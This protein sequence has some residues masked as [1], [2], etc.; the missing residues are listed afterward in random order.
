M[1]QGE[2]HALGLAL[3]LPRATAVSSPFGFLVIDDP[4]QSMDPAKVDGL[5]RVLSE[6]AATRQVVVFTHDDR[7]PAAL[8]QLQLPATIWEVKRREHS[9][10]TLTKRDDAVS[11]YIE[12]AFVLAQ[13]REL[14]GGVRAVAVA[15]LCRYA[16]E[17]ACVE[18]IRARRIG[19]GVPH[20][21]VEEALEDAQKLREKLAMALFDDAGRGDKVTPE[22]ARLGGQQLGQAFVTAFKAANSG[23]HDPYPGDLKLLARHTEK[24]T[25]ALRREGHRK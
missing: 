19:A 7:L 4:V 11:R 16:L 13:T 6:Y 8:K 24:L 15:G 1:S 9:E 10:V 5:A 18:V 2:L 20:A 22:L 23:T 21:E 17:A 14:D 12:D 3:F 25:G